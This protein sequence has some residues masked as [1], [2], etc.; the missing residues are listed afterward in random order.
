MLPFARAEVK[1]HELLRHENVVRLHTWIMTPSKYYLV[2]EY[3]A[4][5]DLLT[6]VDSTAG[7][8]DDAEVRSLVTQLLRGVAFC[9]SLGVKHRDIK[10]ENL[11]LFD[12]PGREVGA[13]GGAAG[14]IGGGLAAS[15][16]LTLK[17]TD[18]GLSELRPI[19]LSGTYCASPAP[20]PNPSPSP[21]TL[22]LTLLTL[23]LTL[24]LTL[25]LTSHARAHPS[26]L[27]P[28]P[29]THRMPSR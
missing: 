20:R 19:G 25:V 27:T 8:L 7:L 12:A 24:A 29:H 18:F 21:F 9:H 15:E 26:P 2:M 1:T 4:R 14:S 3:S 11:L 6:Y 17:I 16:D 28:H 5:G 22:T 13:T 23:T 10:M